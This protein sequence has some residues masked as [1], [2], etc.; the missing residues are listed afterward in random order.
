MFAEQ[1]THAYEMVTWLDWSTSMGHGRAV[2]GLHRVE[3]AH[4]HR[5]S[6][7]DIPQQQKLQYPFT[8]I[9]EIADHMP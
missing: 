4:N 7:K 9:T 1:A 3:M 8:T 5:T 6:A 2:T